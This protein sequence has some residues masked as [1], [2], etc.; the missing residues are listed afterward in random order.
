M[1]LV[2]DSDIIITGNKYD[3]QDVETTYSLSEI[4]AEKFENQKF[5]TSTLV[6]NT[7]ANEKAQAILEYYQMA[8]SISSKF[9]NDTEN[10]GN[11]AI[12]ENPTDGFGNYIAGIEK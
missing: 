11:F 8:L 1:T 5:F 10:I 7:L 3:L 2:A 4:A 6:D 9:V 12:I